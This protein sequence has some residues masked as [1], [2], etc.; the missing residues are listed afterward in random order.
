MPAAHAKTVNPPAW[1]E[2]YTNVTLTVTGDDMD[3]ITAVLPPSVASYTMEVPSGSSRLFILI[4]TN[5]SNVRTWGG[6]VLSDLN[7][8]DVSL[9]LRI[10][11]IPN[12]WDYQIGSLENVVGYSE[13]VSPVVISYNLYRSS[14]ALG[15][16]TKLYTGPYPG[17][18]G[19]QDFPVPTDSTFYYKASINTT[20]GEGELSDYLMVYN[21]W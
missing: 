17:T 4:A 2:G 1:T 3:S 9:T 8:G 16:Y 12:G 21:N 11:P 14:S 10:L 7:P 5:G 19:Y 13:V 18:T 15:P 20:Y 6:R